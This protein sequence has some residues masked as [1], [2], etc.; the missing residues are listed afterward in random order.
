MK[1]A[2]VN[3]GNVTAAVTAKLSQTELEIA[4][5][6]RR[7]AHYA[8]QAGA[9]KTNGILVPSE[10][11][12]AGTIHAVAADRQQAHDIAS[13]VPHAERSPEPMGVREDAPA[14]TVGITATVNSGAARRSEPSSPKPPTNRNAIQN[15]LGAVVPWPVDNTGYVN[16]HYSMMDDE[17][18]KPLIKGSGWP[19]QN[20]SAF[21]QRAAWVNTTAKF[22]D[23]WYCTS[24]QR[25][26]TTNAKGKPKALRGHT[27]ALD[28][29]AIWIDVDIGNPP[30]PD[31]KKPLPKK[32][33][34]TLPEA[35]DAICAFRDK[36]S[37]P[38]FSAVVRTG[39]GL[40]IYWISDKPLLPQDWLPY[41]MG[42]KALLLSEGIK[43]DAGLTTDD[44][45]ILRVPG[46]F[47]HKYD[48]PREV[49]LLPLPL[50]QYDFKNKLAFLTTISPLPS[51]PSPTLVPDIF[52]NSKP[53]DGFAAL[54]PK[55]DSL[56]AGIEKSDKRESLPLDPKPVFKEC[57]FMREAFKTGGK[58]Y[59]NPLWNLSVLCT[60]FMENGNVF[61]HA[62]SKGHATYTPD[63]TQALYDRKVAGRGDRGIGWPSCATIQSNGCTLCK[64]CPHLSKGKS[65][66]HLTRPI[67]VTVTEPEATPRA[68][69]ADPLDFEQVPVAEAVARVNAAGYFVLTLNGDIYKITPSGGVLIQKREGFTNLFAC[70][71]ALDDDDKSINAGTAWKNS[72]QRCEYHS[73]GYWPSDH[74]RPDKSYNLWRGWGVEPKKGNWSIISELVLDVIADGNQGKAN[75][76]LDWFAHM[77]QRPWEKPGVALVFRG[78]KGTGKSL[79]VGIVARAIGKSNTLTTANAKSLFGTYNWH[80]AD[81]LLICAE[82]AFFAGNREHN[83]QLKHLL[84][85]G[86]IEVEQKYGQRFS[87]K[88]MHR[89]IMTS[90]HN[91]V[92]AAS[93]DERRFYVCDVSEKRKADDTYFS[94]L[95]RVLNGED[96]ATL[97]AFMHEL[98]TRDIKGWKAER[99]ARDAAG[100][101]LARQKLLSLE[102]PLQW[103]L[104]ET[105]ADPIVATTQTAEDT[106]VPDELDTVLDE[107]P[108]AR[109]DAAGREQSKAEV[110]SNYRNWA[111]NTQVRGASDYSVAENFW[112]SIKQLLNNTIFPGR[113]LFRQSGANR[114]V[115]WPPR[116]DLIDGF[117][118]LLGGKVIDD[119]DESQT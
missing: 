38:A 37:M 115:I 78:Q 59:A 35:W 8:A 67:T 104:E 1:S 97:A 49:E 28:L 74:D 68:D 53:A 116:Q 26:A 23:C 108:Q 64:N 93:H 107:A 41:A 11:I 27:N 70:R 105:T 12:D 65:P 94:P 113:R 44:V 19:F 56:S 83:D 89:M 29:K 96:A 32:H 14:P 34:D 10:T 111:K 2:A 66:L 77:V 40:H 57:A 17:P 76:I 16:L 81:K 100:D 15:F 18:G 80:L 85:G 58:D 98:C 72:S 86:D 90:N 102:P 69:W 61:A 30:D 24:R 6:R 92:V 109:R 48:P 110:L 71:Q 33:Y 84:T 46:T 87:M 51:V 3:D 60:S 43:C 114:F 117:D 62:I 88:S 5:G 25:A 55:D 91:Q 63:D 95:V 36:V 31:P 119:D 82:E 54:D 47:N 101:D 45:R 13:G 21:V 75:Y 79:L 39:G 9:K 103:L 73:I 7:A 106:G 42:L 4:A 22:K 50:V 99:A 118:R 52:A 112:A 20:I